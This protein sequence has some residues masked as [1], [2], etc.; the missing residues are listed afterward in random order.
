M[1][2]E[3]CRWQGLWVVES[4]YGEGRCMDGRQVARGCDAVG[5]LLGQG[6]EDRGRGPG[7]LRARNFALA[8][9]LL[10]RVSRP[11][12]LKATAWGGTVHTR[13]GIDR[14]QVEGFK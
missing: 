11:P 1:D 10:Q 6:L 5:C 13:E 12:A 3:A 4:G 2:F 8:G 14:G 9:C 7:C